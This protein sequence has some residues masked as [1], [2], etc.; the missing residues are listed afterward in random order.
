VTKES[1][2]VP[3]HLVDELLA[4]PSRGQQ[5]ARLR[6]A[7]LLNARG[8]ERLLDEADR[9]ARDDPGKAQQL[10][11]LC[12]RVAE[13]AGAPAAVPRAEYIQVQTHN[14]SGEFGKALELVRSAHDGYLALGMNLE[15]LRT[16]VGLMVIFLEQGEYRRALGVGRGVLRSLAGEGGPVVKATP[17]QSGLLAASVHQNLGGCYEYMGLFDE[18]LRAY[19]VAEEGYRSLGMTAR[20]GEVGMNRGAILLYLGRGRKGLAAQEAAAATFDEAGL[21]LLRTKALVN[22]GEAHLHLG[23]YRRSLDAFEVARRHLDGGSELADRYLLLRH[24]ADAYLEL[25]L[26]SEALA[27]YREAENLLRNAGMAYDRAQALWGMGTTLTALQELE[28]AERTLQEAATLFGEAGNAPRLSGVMLEQAALLMSRGDRTAA[29]ATAQRALDLVSK[30]ALPVQ[31]VYARLRLADILLPDTEGAEPHLIAASRSAH[32]LAL[33]QLRHRLNERLGRLRRLQNRADDAQALLESAVEDIERLRGNVA[34]NAMR[35]SFLRDKTSAYTELLRLRLDSGKEEDDGARHAFDVAERAKSRALVDLMSGVSWEEPEDAGEPGAGRSVGEARADLNAV[36]SRLLG[37]TLAHT[38]GEARE[39]TFEELRVRAAEL[40]A[41]IGRLR[42]RTAAVSST[43]DPFSDPLTFE[44]L[45]R[46][47]PSDVA[48]LAYHVVD[49]EILAFVGAGEGLRVVRSVGSASAVRRLLR[50]LDAQWDRFRVGREFAERHIALLERSTRQ[51]LSAL[52]AELLAPLEPGLEELALGMV[53]KLAIVPHG[54]LH[55]VPFHAL[56]DGERYAIESYEISY[57]P[58]ATVFAL[59]GERSSGDPDTALVMGVEDPTIPAA[60]AE[61][62]IVAER[63]A[64]ADLRVGEGATIAALV[65][66]VPGRGSLHLA[67]H[68]LFRSDNPMF[69]AIKLD[70]GW[71]TAADAARLRLDGA[72]VTLSA[73][74]SGRAQAVGGDEVLGLARAFLGA[75]AATLVVSLWLVQDETTAKLMGD[76]Y[77]RLRRGDAGPAEALRAAQLELKERRPHPYYWAP[78]VLI[79]KR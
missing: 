40:E 22:I 61:A 47:L 66:G 62:R 17:E 30:D 9:L 41:E 16:N 46:R 31:Q 14:E 68:G 29:L 59:C 57:A 54:P 44:S 79:G 69:S 23:N 34:N 53:P 25:N 77:G 10:G 56:F 27:A 73:C 7:G 18:A 4:L 65:D 64:T 2:E 48:L 35:A 55:A 71:L 70:D 52:H 33:P 63:L 38:D 58:S 28:E 11:T 76:W 8:L 24:T 32:G 60:A 78:F 5:E 42:L 74:E 43:P 67:C 37:D 21:G 15:A 1:L 75:G 51:V 72:L 3:A 39:A 19:A 49:D 13:G 45:S 26:H 6:G 20:V 50:K 12:A 36:Y